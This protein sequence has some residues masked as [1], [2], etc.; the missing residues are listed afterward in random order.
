[1]KMLRIQLSILLLFTFFLPVRQTPTTIPEVSLDTNVSYTF[2]ESLTYTAKIDPSQGISEVSVFSSVNPKPKPAK[3]EGDTAVYTQDLRLFPIPPFAE[4]EYWF[5]LTYE[6]GRFAQSHKQPFFYEDNRFNWIQKTEIDYTINSVEG[7]LGLAEQASDAA[8]NGLEAAYQQL[9][10]LDKKLSA[11]EFPAI[12]IYLYPN[13]RDIQEALQLT[14][15]SWVA[16]HSDPQLNTIMVSVP[17]GEDRIP[18]M[19]RQIP[20]ELMHILLYRYMDTAI[21]GNYDTLPTWLNE[22]LA[23]LNEL[24]PDP[25]NAVILYDASQSGNLLPMVSLC[26]RFPSGAS[27]ALVAYAQSAAFTSYL[28]QQYGAS[29]IEALLK[30]YADGLE[31]ERGA[32][33]A[34][35]KNLSQLEQQWII[36]TFGTQTS[37]PETEQATTWLILLGLIVLL[38]L[39]SI[40]LIRRKGSASH[41]D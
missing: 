8:K 28:K 20:H 6:D 22:G 36:D 26:H 21:N 32:E 19:Q 35:G 17:A 12:N 3:I 1:M 5:G 38:P 16:G 27:Q 18:E 30:S 11:I 23:T 24:N 13:A 40:L 39:F 37:P 31:C 25:N 10:F 33:N 2:G 9:P 7:D 34:L 41:D 15:Q 29:G 14:G 4:I